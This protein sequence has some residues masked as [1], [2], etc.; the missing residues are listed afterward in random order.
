MLLKT[1]HSVS[2][3]FK[4]FAIKW[5]FAYT[6]DEFIGKLDFE[7]EKE[8]GKDYL[9]RLGRFATG[10]DMQVQFIVFHDELDW[11]NDRSELIIVS[12]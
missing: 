10:Y 7:M 5:D 2:Y 4:L 8:F 6:Y 3:C 12:F 1:T 11:A 9:C